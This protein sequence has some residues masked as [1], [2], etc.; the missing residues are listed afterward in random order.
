MWICSL[1]VKKGNCSSRVWDE[2]WSSLYENLKCHIAPSHGVFFF[3]LVCFT[4]IFPEHPSCFLYPLCPALRVAG[5]ARAQ[6]S[7]LTV[8]P[9]QGS[10]KTS[11]NNHVY[12]MS[13]AHAFIFNIKLLWETCWEMNTVSVLSLVINALTHCICLSSHLAKLVCTACVFG[14][15]EPLFLEHTYFLDISYVHMT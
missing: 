9:G 11:V 13:I 15:F 6:P 7:C 12:F 5:S 2:K 14:T 1:N 8:Q 3:F 10:T 4:L